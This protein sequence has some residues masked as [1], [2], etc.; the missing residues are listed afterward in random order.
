MLL[1]PLTVRGRAARPTADEC[2][3]LEAEAAAGGVA[4]VVVDV[5]AGA[6][7]IVDVKREMGGRVVQETGERLTPA[8]DVFAPPRTKEG[9]RS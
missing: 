6:R 2:A 7:A 4:R 1:P 8:R 5:L 3:Q 9:R